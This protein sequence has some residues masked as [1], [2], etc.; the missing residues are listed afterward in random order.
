MGKATNEP[1]DVRQK[2]LF[3]NKKAFLSLLRDCIKAEWV[4][5]LDADSLKIIETSFILQDFRKKEADVVYEATIGSGRQKVIFY[6]LLELQSRVDYRMPYRLLLY[7]VEILRHCYNNAN[8]K[9]RRRKNFKFPAVVPIVFFSGSRKWTASTSLRGMF[10]GESRFGASLIDFSY[11]LVDVKGYDDESVVGFQSRLLKV[12]MMLEKSK[13]ALELLDIARRYE[14]EIS[15]LDE[16]ELRILAA[17]LDILDNL[18]GTDEVG[19]LRDA[20]EPMS[21]ER[22][23]GMLVDLIAN[24]K[25]RERQLINQGREEG[26]EEGVDISAGVMTA[27]IENVPIEEVA[28]NFGISIAKVMQIQSVLDQFRPKS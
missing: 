6:V 24:E 13:N 23:S 11:S 10:D 22:V 27:L 8:A 12:M 3:R 19:G 26:R 20:L 9:E 21:A 25:K 28:N 2:L 4:D 17:A 18:Y 5:D 14:G 1:H 16:E 7:I 15:K